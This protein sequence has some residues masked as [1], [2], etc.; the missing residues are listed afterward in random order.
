MT[1]MGSRQ[2]VSYLTPADLA[3]RWGCSPEHI[4]RL[5]KRGE[6][7]AMKLGRRGWRIAPSDAEAFEAHHINEPE[8][9][10]ELTIRPTLAARQPQAPVIDLA[11]VY[12]PVVR[13]PV[14]WRR[15]IVQ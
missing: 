13:G 12:A 7:R 5:C 11:G 10:P 14:P 8:S 2:A 1:V 4:Q 9:A 15:E 6:L 3:V